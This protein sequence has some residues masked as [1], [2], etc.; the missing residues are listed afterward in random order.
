MKK[1]FTTL[2]MLAAF[3]ASSA[4][5]AENGVSDKEI[6]LGQSAAMT[7]AAGELGK[8]MRAGA[9]AYF[10]SVNEQGGVFGRKIKLIT[11]DDGYEPERAAAN[12]KTLIESS[13]V[14]ALFGYVGT[15][16]SNAAKPIFSA[17]KVPFFAPYTGAESMRHPVNRYIFNVRSSYFAETAEIIRFVDA[18]RMKNIAVF[19][20]NDA[21]GQAGLEGVKQAMLKYN[22]KP[23]ALA[24]VERNSVDVAAAVDTIAA[25]KPEAIV[26]I[27]AYKSCAAFIR[28]MKARVPG[29][30]FWN[31][32]FVGSRALA[33]ELGDMGRGVAISQVVPFPWDDITP[34]TK[35]HHKHIGKDMSFTTLEG[36]IAA[37]VFVEGLRKTGKGLTREKFVDALEQ[38]GKIDVGGF[39]VKYTPDNH[40]GSKFV[41][42]TLISHNK[43][44]IR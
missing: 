15:P 23:G 9:E 14:F 7:G 24:T 42:L 32:S 36:F 29:V 6:L 28:A 43:K 2:A 16:T 27:S 20:Q 18:P 11:L 39:E 8:Q 44:F 10:N 31:V 22:A 37:K 41:D 4:L 30:S 1:I 38:A 17:A 35:E 3:Q 33:D 12:T 26:M 21:Y 5:H 13:K 19:Y 40:D 34:V 25:T